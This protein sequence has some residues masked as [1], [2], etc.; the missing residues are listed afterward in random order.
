MTTIN[1][2]CIGFSLGYLITF[3]AIPFLE[4]PITQYLYW[5][6]RTGDKIY[7]SIANYD[8]RPKNV[9]AYE[10]G[11]RDQQWRA[12]QRIHEEY[13]KKYRHTGSYGTIVGGASNVFIHK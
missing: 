12:Q 6:E 11:L 13:R 4:T 1:K 8:W 2:V 3:L 10:K 7:W 9:I 5:A